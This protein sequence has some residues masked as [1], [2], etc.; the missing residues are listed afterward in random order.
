M[1]KFD[2]DKERSPRARVLKR[3]RIVMGQMKALTA[4]KD[5]DEFKRI[6]RK[7]T[8]SSLALRGLMML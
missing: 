5:E 1:D 8:G 3:E 6:W 4:L 7:F 2:Q